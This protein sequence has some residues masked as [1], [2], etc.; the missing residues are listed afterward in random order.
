MRHISGIIAFVLISSMAFY[1]LQTR[2]VK[3][4]SAHEPRMTS[5]CVGHHIIELP[6]GFQRVS[7]ITGIFKSVESTTQDPYFDVMVN[8]NSFTDISFSQALDKRRSELKEKSDS[9]VDVF[10]SEQKT[11]DGAVMFRVRKIDDAY[12]SE[13]NFLRGSSLVTIKLDSFNNEYAAAEDR[14]VKFASAFRENQ[15]DWFAQG[16]QYFCFGSV[17]I[18]GDFKDESG[19][20]LFKNNEG[21]DFEVDINTYIPDASKPLIAR[22]SGPDSLLAVFNVDHKVLR[23]GE[24][25]VANMHAQEWLGWAKLSSEDDAKS[26]KFI[27]ETLRKEPGR[28]APSISLT[29]N[30]GKP[31]PGGG[32]AKTNM[33]EHEAIQLWDKVVSS[34]RPA[35]P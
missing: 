31:L 28:V 35:T 3:E 32:T 13:I 15:K 19:S 4:M 21:A 16:K 33:S 24:R 7:V 2:G 27:L 25:D 10:E 17:S 23:S 30:T 9:A 20:F 26:F 22:I 11:S 1:Q 12:V 14:L 18:A 6:D 34:I 5:H 8:E 29:F